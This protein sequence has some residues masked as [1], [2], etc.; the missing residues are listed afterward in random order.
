MEHVVRDH[1]EA[2]RYE[3][4]IDGVV[5]GIADYHPVPRGIAVV[6]TEIEHGRRGQGL[7]DVLV[8]GVLDDLRARELTVVPQCWFVRQFGQDHPEYSDVFAASG[9]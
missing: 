4:V 9:G 7:G 5:V 8:R 1:P 3:L 2:Q 6:H